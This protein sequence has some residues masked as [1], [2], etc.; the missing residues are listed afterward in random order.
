MPS[1]DLIEEEFAAVVQL[2]AT[3][4]CGSPRPP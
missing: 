1:A 4:P 2:R 3:H